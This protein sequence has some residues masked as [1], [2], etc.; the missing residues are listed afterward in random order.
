MICIVSPH[1]DDAALSCA[2]HALTWR[3]AGEEVLVVNVFTAAGTSMPLSSLMRPILQASQ[4]VD[5]EQYVALRL[6]ED[7]RCLDALGLRA[8]QLG[9]TDAGFRG[10]GTPDYPTLAAL[11][12]GRLLTPELDLVAAVAGALAQ[13]VRGV[14][15]DGGVGDVRLAVAPLGIGRHVDHLITRA[16]CEQVFGADRLAFYADMPYARAPWRWSWPDLQRLAGARKSIKPMTPVK[17]AALAHYASQMPLMFRG[18][19]RYPELVLL[20]QR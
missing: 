15:G 1:L 18:T 5:A 11:R 2:D 10:A 19:P 3:A 6:R 20:P 16:A 8:C 4:V 7:H 12:T 14:G 13:A 17:R 9:F